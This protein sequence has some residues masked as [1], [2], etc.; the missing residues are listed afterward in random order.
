MAAI[1][2]LSQNERTLRYIIELNFPVNS[3]NVWKPLFKLFIS[4]RDNESMICGRALELLTRRETNSLRSSPHWPAMVD[5][6]LIS[7]LIHVFTESKNDDVLIS[8]YLLLLNS[9]NEYPRVK[10]DLLT[11]KNAFSSMLKHTRSTNNQ[12][13]TLLG[14]VLACLSE[15][16]S[17]I[18]PMVDQGLIE[19]LIIL[20]DKERTPQRICSYFDCLANIVSYSFEY[21]LKLANSKLFLSLIINH[22]LEEFDLRLSLSVMRFIRQLVFKNEEIQTLFAKNGACE[23]ILGALSASSKDLQL[24]S[25]EAIQAISYKNPYVQQIML[26]E[27][28]L[29]QL[30][31]LLEKTN[32][33]TLQIS[34]VCTLWTLCG[35]NSSRKREVATIIGVKKLISFYSIKSDEHL[36]AVTDALGE[37]AKR[38]AS[39]KM[40]IQEEINRAQGIPHLIRL[41]KSDNEPLV[42]SIL[43]TLQLIVCA[44]GFVSNRRNQE[45]IVKN[46]GLPLLVALMMHAKSEIIQVEAAQVLACIALCMLS[47]KLIK[48]KKMNYSIFSKYSMFN[49][50]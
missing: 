49:N 43:K 23:H 28:A 33:P 3:Y 20:I 35:N 25:I 30:L 21:Q 10:I 29:E 7:T 48:N 12:I 13:V 44:P 27:N 11:I 32:L 16:K 42:L 6:G 19:S 36:L 15:N 38:T 37:L 31:S 4:L 22:Y 24:A 9:A 17:L 40:N 14:R 39:V 1:A 47:Y 50:Y 41:L 34:I 46:D 26:R 18:E 2:A 8:A 5:N 45:T